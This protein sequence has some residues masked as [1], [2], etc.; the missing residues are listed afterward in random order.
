MRI[1]DTAGR[2]I[3]GLGTKVFVELTGG[4]YVT[5]SRRVL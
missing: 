3:S 2:R 5:I 1:V 4:R